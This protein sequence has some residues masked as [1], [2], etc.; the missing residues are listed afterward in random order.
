MRSSRRR[1]HLWRFGAI[2]SAVT[3]LH[4]RKI[5]VAPL[6][7][8]LP[9]VSPPNDVP[10]DLFPAGSDFEDLAAQIHSDL[11]I[12]TADKAVCQDLLSKL[13]ESGD[14]LLASRWLRKMRACGVDLDPNCYEAI[15]AAHCLQGLATEGEMILE[16]HAKELASEGRRPSAASYGSLAE[17]FA[18][19]GEVEK[20]QEYLKNMKSFDLPVEMRTYA[21]VIESL[22]QRGQSDAARRWLEDAIRKGLTP[23]RRCFSATISAFAKESRL[24]EAEGVLK[25]MRE[26]NVD[27]DVQT[28]GWLLMASHM[29]PSNRP[30]S[31]AKR[32]Q[33]HTKPE[34][35]FRQMLDAGIVPDSF[36]LRALGKA[37]GLER[38]S[39][40]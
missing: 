32:K 2:A 12:R 10:A 19:R 20:A 26:A 8:A 21:A 36:V 17:T 30:T 38:L 35:I 27:A 37:V 14:P 3:V 34:D 25:A 29:A 11:E 22:A 13:A 39:P 31:R 9:Q 24:L 28:W 1:C 15:V 16:V 5:L 7:F 33:S 40:G 23:S 18:E 4:L 6:C